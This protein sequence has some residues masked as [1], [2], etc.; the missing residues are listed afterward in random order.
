MGALHE[1]LAARSDRRNV[2]TQERQKVK[3]LFTKFPDRLKGITERYEP[4]AESETSVVEK[5]KKVTT[6]ARN[7]LDEAFKAMSRAM[8][9]D[10]SI[11]HTNAGDDSKSRADVV[12][13]EEV[14]LK[15]VPVSSLLD[16]SNDLEKILELLY[17]IPTLDPTKEWI[18][19]TATGL[20][21]CKTKKVRTRPEP[22]AK[23]VHEYPEHKQPAE[24]RDYSVNVEVGV[25]TQTELSGEITIAQKNRGI[26]ECRELH[27]AVKKA[28]ARAN[29]AEIKQVSIGEKIFNRIRDALE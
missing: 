23:V 15:S 19:S 1:A 8:D 24:L 10:C 3:S 20:W 7:A 9:L 6:T 14:L 26:A 5:S 18:Q 21:E 2:A 13:E 4:K 12:V 29:Q 17:A 27:V 28:I 25:A 22:H 11:T 16:L